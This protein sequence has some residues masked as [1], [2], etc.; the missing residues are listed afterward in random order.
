[1]PTIIPMY[2]EGEEG[3]KEKKEHKKQ[4]TTREEPYELTDE[5]KALIERVKKRLHD[6]GSSISPE[7][8]KHLGS[9]HPDED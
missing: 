2:P 3:G 5:Q 1:M 4:S 9:L 8:A 6:A 7:A